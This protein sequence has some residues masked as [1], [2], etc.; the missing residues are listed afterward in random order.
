MSIYVL[1]KMYKWDGET[2]AYHQNGQNR[3][4]ECP[5]KLKLQPTAEQKQK[6]KQNNHEFGEWCIS[7]CTDN[8]VSMIRPVN[9]DICYCEVF[10]I[11][12]IGIRLHHSIKIIYLC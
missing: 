2:Q 11:R 1:K 6:Q 8:M 9:A 7:V 12:D 4:D 10:K 3:S 5:H